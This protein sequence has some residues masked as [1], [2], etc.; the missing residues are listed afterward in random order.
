MRKFKITEINKIT[1][2]PFMIGMDTWWI[3]FLN[4]GIYPTDTTLTLVELS[5][6]YKQVKGIVISDLLEF[7]NDLKAGKVDFID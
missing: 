5:E 7:E 2:N 6:L 4:E 3:V 1:K